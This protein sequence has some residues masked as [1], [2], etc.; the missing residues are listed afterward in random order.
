GHD[1]WPKG[2]SPVDDDALRVSSA[3]AQRD[4]AAALKDPVPSILRRSVG[5]AMHGVVLRHA[6]KPAELDRLLGPWAPVL[7]PVMPPARS[8]PRPARAR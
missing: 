5:R 2:L 1:P 3:L 6:F 7:G 4:A 8:E